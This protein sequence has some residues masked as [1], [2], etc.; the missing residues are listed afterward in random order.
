M[1]VSLC[2]SGSHIRTLSIDTHLYTIGVEPNP[3]HGANSK[4]GIPLPVTIGSSFSPAHL[5]VQSDADSENMSDYVGAGTSNDISI[6]ELLEGRNKQR[7]FGEGIKQAKHVLATLFAPC[8]GCPFLQR[9]REILIDGLSYYGH[10]FPLLLTDLMEISVRL[11]LPG[12]EK[13]PNRTD[14]GL[15]QKQNVHRDSDVDREELLKEAHNCRKQFESIHNMTLID[16]YRFKEHYGMVMFVLSE[17]DEAIVSFKEAIQLAIENHFPQRWGLLIPSCPLVLLLLG[18]KLFDF[19]LEM[20]Q[21]SYRAGNKEL[22][23][24][25]KRRAD[26]SA[27]TE[28]EKST[29]HEILDNMIL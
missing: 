27:R 19:Y 12:A 8:I 4:G 21:S 22:F 25:C 29:F 15:Q 18:D 20:A 23:D 24:I 10:N 6:A 5:L 13:P 2:E 11:I 9:A 28:E 16:R 3:I 1:P 7:A 14:F 26:E 17:P